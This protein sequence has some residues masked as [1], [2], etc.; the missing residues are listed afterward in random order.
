MKVIFEVDEASTEAEVARKI[1]SVRGKRSGAV[2]LLLQGLAQGR[3]T[4]EAFIAP[5]QPWFRLDIAN[6]MFE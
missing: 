5:S 1:S 3:E 2:T 6:S 4:A